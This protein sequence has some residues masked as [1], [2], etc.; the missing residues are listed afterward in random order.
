MADLSAA[1][2]DD[3]A[4]FFK[5]YYAPNNAVVAIVGDV[6]TKATLAKMREVLRVD[7]DAAGAAAGGH[8]RAAAD[9]KSAG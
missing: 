6:D 8:D 3:V 1:T 7:P 2:V 5:T 4:A 9:A